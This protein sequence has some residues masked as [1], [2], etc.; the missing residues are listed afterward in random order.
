MHADKPMDTTKDFECSG[1]QG[2]GLSPLP[3]LKCSTSTPTC[4]QLLS[5]HFSLAAIHQFQQ[6]L[7]QFVAGF[8]GLASIPILALGK[9]CKHGAIDQKHEP[10]SDAFS[11][12]SIETEKIKLERKKEHKK[13]EE[14]HMNLRAEKLERNKLV[15]SRMQESK[16]SEEEAKAKQEGACLEQQKVMPGMMQLFT[17][18]M[19]FVLLLNSSNDFV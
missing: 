2:Q 18:H 8:G 5:H 4:K 16:A 17:Q 19:S 14:L 15:A 7:A 10:L 13:Q 1:L 9:K 12:D 6:V 3:E 11:Q